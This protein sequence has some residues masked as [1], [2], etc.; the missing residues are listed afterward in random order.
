MC[1]GCA[2]TRQIPCENTP[3]V[4]DCLQ[5]RRSR[6]REHASWIECANQDPKKS[7][8]EKTTIDVPGSRE[9]H[10]R[11]ILITTSVE[12]NRSRKH[13]LLVECRAKWLKHCCYNIF[14]LS[15]VLRI[16]GD[17]KTASSKYDPRLRPFLLPSVGSMA[18]SL[19]VHHCPSF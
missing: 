15:V 11:R 1:T 19:K 14:L 9:D 18:F 12:R 6:D 17:R 8:C 7:P 5:G 13:D 3:G 10:K 4:K 2:E 16:Y